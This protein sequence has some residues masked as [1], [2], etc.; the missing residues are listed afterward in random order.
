MNRDVTWILPRLSNGHLAPDLFFCWWAILFASSMLARYEPSAW[1]RL[2]DL[3]R[4]QTAV[5]LQSI[6]D[7]GLDAV[8][9][10]AYRILLE[11]FGARSLR[12]D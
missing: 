7:T 9:E 4:E 2:L 5:P 11:P 6:L 1:V 8:P 10:T 3:D 12:A